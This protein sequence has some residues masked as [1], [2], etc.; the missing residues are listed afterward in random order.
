M[1]GP[2]EKF[3]VSIYSSTK[4]CF[5]CLGKWFLRV[6]HAFGIEPI[7]CL[8]YG[9]GIVDATIDAQ[10]TALCSWIIVVCSIHA[11][12]LEQLGEWTMT[13]DDD[14]SYATEQLSFRY[15]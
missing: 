14:H 1:Y 6:G 12:M 7:F 2:P 8:C 4:T 3:P 10:N 15:T 11:C 13:I 5:S 9:R